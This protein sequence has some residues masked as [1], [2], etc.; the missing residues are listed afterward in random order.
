MARNRSPVT[1]EMVTIDLTGTGGVTA[2]PLITTNTVYTN[3]IRIDDGDKF[4]VSFKNTTSY[5]SNVT[6]VW[7]QSFQAPD[8]EYAADITYFQVSTIASAV[9][10]N[11][12]WNYVSIPYITLPYMRFRI[13]GA[14]YNSASTVA[15]KLTRQIQ[16]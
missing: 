3:A 8:T 14:A 6:I 16:G 1:K 7:E 11:G 4:L 15:V 10:T 13:T 2:I 9:A 12:T 5:T